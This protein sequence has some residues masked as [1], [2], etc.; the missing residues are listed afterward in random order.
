VINIFVVEHI[1]PRTEPMSLQPDNAPVKN[2]I[3][4]IKK[5]V[6]IVK[7]KRKVSAVMVDGEFCK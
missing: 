4:K 3:K 5:I 7:V 6:K 2:K 1:Q